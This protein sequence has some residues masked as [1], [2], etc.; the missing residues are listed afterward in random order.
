MILVLDSGVERP[1]TPEEQAEIEAL[2]SIPAAAPVPQTVTRRQARQA[3]LLAGLLDDVPLA[4]ETIP[5]ETQR[6]LAQIEW[7]DS[8]EFVRTRPLVIQI[9]AAIG[10]DSDG[11]DQMFI[12]A[13]TL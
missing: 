6:R 1:A 5:D 13:S 9:A 2:R 7:E 8:L 4:I 11:L 3:L 10:L 12:T